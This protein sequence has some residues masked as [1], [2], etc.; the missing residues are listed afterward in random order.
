MKVCKFGGS[1]LA[2]AGQV[3]KVCNIIKAD[4]SRRVVVVSAPG[5]R[6]DD[7]IKVTDLLISCAE[8]RLSG[9]NTDAA[10]ALIVERF[11]GMAD[12]LNLD[13]QVVREITD[14]LTACVNGDIEDAERFMC[15]MKAA[16]EDNSARL[17]AAALRSQGMPA[18]YLNPKDAGLLLTREHGNAQILPESYDNLAKITERD[19]ITVFPGFFGYTTDGT[20]VTFPRG[21]SDITGAVL[22]AAVKAELYENFT[23]VDSVLSADPRIIDNPAPVTELTFREMRELSYAGFGVLHDEAIQPAVAAGI[24]I[25]VK[26]TNNPTAPGTFILPERKYTPGRVVGI[27]SSA[28]F[29]TVYVRKYLLNREI[30]FGRRLLQI[31]EEEGVSFE[32]MPSG[33]DDMSVIVKEANMGQEKEERIVERIQKELAVDDVEVEHGLALVMIVGEGMRYS[34]GIMSKAVDAL[35]AKGVNIEMVNQGS[36][37]INVMFGVKDTDRKKA[38]QAIYEAFFD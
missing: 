26:N 15:E 28:G 20:I 24:H 1:S 32:H 16:G 35:A 10:L 2:D 11:A 23:D 7:D 18:D 14:N 38:V 6:F 19:T 3:I 17:V 31:F 29:T 30:G 33:I 5:K 34:I 12:E 37:E 8:K 36:S 27:A 4:E 21:G 13:E 25:C 22:A 9:E